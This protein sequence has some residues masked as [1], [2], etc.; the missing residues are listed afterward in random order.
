MA[1]YDIGDAVRISASFTDIDGVAANP[2]VLKL[3][4]RD[5]GGTETPYRAGEDAELVND[6]PGEYHFDLTLTA[7]GP[8]YYRWRAT[9][10]VTAADEGFVKAKR[11]E[12]SNPLP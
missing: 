5:P 3:V 2:T 9:G 6:G 1:S 8:W 12:F 11:T 10:A 7:E 4:I